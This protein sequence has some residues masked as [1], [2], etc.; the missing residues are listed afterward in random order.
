MEVDELEKV[1]RTLNLVDK[2]FSSIDRA[3]SALFLTEDQYS[4]LTQ[5]IKKSRD[6]L[7]AIIAKR[8]EDPQNT[9]V[10]KK[11]DEWPT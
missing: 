6:I 9:L 11:V 8:R 7:V 10:Q 1:L 4:P 2:Y 3:E 5:L